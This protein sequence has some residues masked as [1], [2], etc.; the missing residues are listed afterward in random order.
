MGAR[1]E[2]MRMFTRR[3]RR[4]PLMPVPKATTKALVG[5]RRVQARAENSGPETSGF[6]CLVWERGN[7][8]RPCARHAYPRLA[9]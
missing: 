2:I 3:G 8:L 6:G 1:L 7:D 9:P 4:F 5:L